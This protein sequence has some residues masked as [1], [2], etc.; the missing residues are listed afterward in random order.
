MTPHN[1]HL[2]DF[3]YTTLGLFS[4]IV[5]KFVGVLNVNTNVNSFLPSIEDEI[6]AVILA[7]IMATTSYLIGKLMRWINKQINK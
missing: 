1:H 3:F 7:A 4:F 5:A 2:Y 6:K